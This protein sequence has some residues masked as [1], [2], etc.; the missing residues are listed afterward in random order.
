MT[1]SRELVEAARIVI[2]AEAA[3]RSASDT[4]MAALANACVATV[5]C[6]TF[7]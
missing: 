5:E 2:K 6:W 1:P 4:Y 3:M 7:K